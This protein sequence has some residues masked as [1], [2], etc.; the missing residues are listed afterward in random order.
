MKTIF[1]YTLSLALVFL[2]DTVSLAG[3]KEPD[4]SEQY[5]IK[6]VGDKHNDTRLL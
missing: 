3:N 1:C 6:L 4:L 2:A 5:C